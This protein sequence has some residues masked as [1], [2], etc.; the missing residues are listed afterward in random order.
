MTLLSVTHYLD[1]NTLEAVWV[2][3]QGDGSLKRVR[4]H[5][6]SSEQKQEFID[7]TGEPK[8]TELAGW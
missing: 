2:E 7:E 1:S 3:V 5:S 4:C 8:Y 6:Y